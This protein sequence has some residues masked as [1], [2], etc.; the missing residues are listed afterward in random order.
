MTM[1][2]S[3][4]LIPALILISNISAAPTR[5]RCEYRDN[6]LGIDDPAPHL[7]WQSDTTARNWSQSAYQ[8][9]VASSAKQ[10]RAG[11]GDIWDSGRQSSAESVGI[12]YAGPPLKSSTR[13]FW[14]VRVWDASGKVSQAVNPAWWETALLAKS[15]WTAKWISRKDAEEEA[16]RAGIRWV[17]ARE[18]DAFAAP[19]QPQSSFAPNLRLRKRRATR[20]FS[21]VPSPDSEP[22]SM[23]ATPEARTAAFRNSIART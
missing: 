22:R 5:L 3:A 20:P 6:P 14:T 8:I 19:P 2:L 18:Q 17:W 13:Y 4:L 21:C 16:D 1:R 10:L 15:D 7:S 11:K 12:A 9:L 23:V